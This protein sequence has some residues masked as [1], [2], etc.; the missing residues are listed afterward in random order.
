[1]R[2]GINVNCIYASEGP[3]PKDAARH[4]GSGALHTRDRHAADETRRG[5]GGLSCISFVA[6]RSYDC[7]RGPILSPPTTT[8]RLG[9]L[10][11]GGDDATQ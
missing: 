3:T 5:R 6:I 4:G 7:P 1:M 10:K 9:V 11:D 8:C 2:I